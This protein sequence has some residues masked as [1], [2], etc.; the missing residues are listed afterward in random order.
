MND[1]VILVNEAN[2][3]IGTEEKM[4]AHLEGKLHRAFSI[5]V[6]NKKGELLLQRRALNKYH[7]GGEW[8]NTVCSHPRPGESYE[9]AVHRRLKEEM[10]FDCELKEAFSFIYRAEFE[11]GLT[12]HEY[13]RIFLGKYEGRVEP[14]PEEVMDTQWV[15]LQELERALQK[16]PKEYSAWLKVIMVHPKLDIIKDFT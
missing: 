14:N 15:S 11:N 9:Q 1:H 8:T 13:D 12:E 16:R 5:F 7:S 6:F 10:G 3:P 2:E 4:K